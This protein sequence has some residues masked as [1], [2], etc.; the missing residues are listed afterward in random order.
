[1]IAQYG[2]TTSREYRS[3]ILG[4][5][6]LSNTSGLI[7]RDWLDTASQNEDVIENVLEP[8]IWGVDVG[9][10]DKESDRSVIVVRNDKMIVDIKEITDLDPVQLGYRIEELIRAT[11]KIKR[12]IAVCVDGLGVG[13][14][15]VS[16][17]KSLG[18]PHKDVKVGSAATRGKDRFMQL[19]DQLWWECRTWFEQMDARIPNHTGLITELSLPTYNQDRGKIKV[20][21]K[22]SIRKR[23][24]NK[25]TDFAD[26]LC[27]TFAIS[28][29]QYRGK[30]SHNT[31]IVPYNLER[32][33]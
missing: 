32:Y 10:G 7:P 19:R 24:K 22:K 1:M 12:P 23:Y 29:K 8:Y 4:E 16:V 28:P 31:P 13:T 2:G 9:G 17:L 5:F 6:P 18:V 30:W 11:P 26:A 14:G 3:H 33:E 27:L 25:S 15:T 20:E 21:D